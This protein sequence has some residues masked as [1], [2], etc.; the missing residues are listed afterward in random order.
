M[1]KLCCFAAIASLTAFLLLTPAAQADCRQRVVV[2]NAAAV[3][4]KERV[5]VAPAV[6]AVYQPFAV[7]VPA[8]GAGYVQP[9]NQPPVVA[10]A[11]NATDT[12]TAILAEL[13]RLNGR[14]D[15]LEKRSGA[16]KPMDRE[17]P[18][19]PQARSNVAVG[20][21]LTA[22]RSKCAA[23]HSRGKEADG[24]NLVLLDGDNLVSLTDRQEAKILKRLAKNEMPP[25]NN[26]Q[27]IA[28]L[29]DEEYAAIIA[30]L[31]TRK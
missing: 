30:L 28:A 27:G 17:Q 11:N 5:V 15:A 6:V 12:N 21:G 4:I 2:A 10:Q 29:N 18:N 23:C 22:L 8:Y 7:L 25:P 3:V 20:A 16:I 13:K 9:T 24:G 26:K 31:D 1:N 14:L 19:E